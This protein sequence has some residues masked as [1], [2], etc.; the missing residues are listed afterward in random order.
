MKARHLLSVGM[1]ICVASTA[2]AAVT[3]TSYTMQNGETGSFVYQD[4]TY[5]PCVAGECTTS[6]ANLTGG[7]GSLTDGVVPPNSWN[8]SGSTQVWVGWTSIRPSIDFN[9]SGSPII[10]KVNLYLDNTPGTGDVRLPISVDIG[11]FNYLVAPDASF[12]PRWV[13]FDIPDNSYSSLNIGLNADGAGRWVMLGEVSFD[14]AQGA[15][16]EPGTVGIVGGGLLALTA[17]RLRR[18]S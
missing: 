4:T 10:S 8:A 12:G 3:V 14:E 2:S 16:P 1:L 18:R 15:V 13:S 6:L 17:R 5:L 7:T 11:S 9:F